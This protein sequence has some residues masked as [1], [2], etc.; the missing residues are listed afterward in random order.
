MKRFVSLFITIVLITSVF[1]FS[2]SVNAEEYPS[3]WAVDEVFA[4]RE[5]GLFTDK[6]SVDYQKNITRE[7]FCELVVKLYIK[8]S[9]E[10]PDVGED[11]FMDTDNAEI[12]KAYGLGIVKGVSATEFAPNN[13]ITRQEICVMLTRCIDVAI[14]S[15]DINAYNK[16]DF[17]DASKIA[18]W[19]LPA[20]NYA[21]DN[22]IIKGIGEKEINPLG[23]TT[24]E[25]SILLVYRTYQN[26]RHLKKCESYWCEPSEDNIKIDHET[27]ITYVNN[28]INVCF[29]DD[30]SE[31]KKQEVFNYIGGE[32]VG[33]MPILNKYQIKVSEKNLSEL[34]AI[35]D[36]LEKMP[37]VWLATYNEVFELDDVAISVNDPEWNRT[38]LNGT[39]DGDWWLEDLG[40]PQAWSYSEYFSDITIGVT[41]AGV[42]NNHEDLNVK[43]ISKNNFYD[44]KD[45]SDGY[46]GTHVAGTIGAL[47]N[48]NKGIT[49]I[50]KNAEIINYCSTN[51]KYKPNFDEVVNSISKLVQSDAKVINVSIG[52]PTDPQKLINKKGSANKHAKELSQLMI[53]LLEDGYD[54]IIVQS[55]GNGFSRKDLNGD[56]KVNSSDARG[57]DAFY[58][59]FFAGINEDNCKESKTISQS[60]ILERIIV[61]GAAGKKD[62]KYYQCNF[63]NGG[64]QVDICA[65]GWQILSTIPDNKYKFSSGT[66]MATPIVTGITALAW[67]IYPEL[68]GSEIKA[69]VCDPENSIYTAYE[70]PDSD[71]EKNMGAKPLINAQLIVEDVIALRDGDKHIEKIRSVY[72]GSYVASQGETAL[73]L[74]IFKIGDDYK[75]QFDFESL[76]GR[77]NAKEGEYYMD[78]SYD[79]KTDMYFFDAYEWT[80]KPAWYSMLDLS[81]KYK[82]GV[83]SGEHPTRFK[84]TQVQ[85]YTKPEV[86]LDQLVGEYRGTYEPSQGTAGITLEI[87]KAGEEYKAT[88]EFYNLPGQSNTKEGS[89]TYNVSYSELDGYFLFEGD[90]WIERPG[91]YSMLDLQGYLNGNTLSGES[92]T[93]FKVERVESIIAPSSVEEAI[94]AHFQVAIAG[95]GKV[96]WHKLWESDSEYTLDDIVEENKELLLKAAP[97]SE[98]LSL[99]W[100]TEGQTWED[101]ATTYISFF[102]DYKM[103]SFNY[104]AGTDFKLSYEILNQEEITNGYKVAVKYTLTGS[105][106]TFTAIGSYNVIN[107]DGMWFAMLGNSYAIYWD[108][109]LQDKL[110]KAWHP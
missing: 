102:Y 85:Q 75:A 42:D 15:S 32:V 67:S 110:S 87:Y 60:D 101:V 27:E 23:N 17:A 13:P 9:G 21:Y 61:V 64:K 97:E 40:L 74:A 41:D 31:S 96:N 56:G 5:M 80:E 8:L 46:H 104:N 49:G 79:P 63:S 1:P 91:W 34:I 71:V 28:I 107:S 30:T 50:V 78:V 26:R 99:P 45:G 83:I 90:E 66:S 39:L 25:Q 11:V 51:E 37:C 36:E 72:K 38:A 18:D 93:S 95:L 53:K 2:F 12:L 22:E 92:P 103:P 86:Y 100:R 58:N 81:G 54:F 76:P 73:T 24:C 77:N 82:D 48:N 20:V 105:K 33:K 19:A 44:S 10:T 57:V 29:E 55:S 88:C 108:D 62:G 106:G 6:T 109:T 65:P 84:V 94:D 43:T 98:W 89:F 52:K 70:S 7:E 3:E 69:V 35:C 68:S 16:T 4:A 47:M 59:C 14:E